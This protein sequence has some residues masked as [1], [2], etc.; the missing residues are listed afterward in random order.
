MRRLYHYPLCALSRLVRIYLKERALDHELVIDFPWDRKNTFSEYHVFSDLPTLVD[1]DGIVLEG[2]YAIVEYLEQS[3]RSKSLLGTTQK[4]KAESRRIVTLF[5]GMFFAEITK[6]IVFEKVMKK[7][8][9]RSP[10]DSSSI[11]KGHGEIKK[12]FDFIA[13]LID[14]RNWL[15][16]DEF[17]LADISAAAQISCIDYIGSIKWDDYPQ[18]KDWYVRIKSRPSFRDILQ[19]RISNVTPPSYYQDLDF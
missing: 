9:E 1:L 4:E 6:N 5:N 16:G 10:P 13:Q 2:W 11:R 14:C 3:Y 18:V 19:D 17:S 15:A 7:Y 12:Y 8:M